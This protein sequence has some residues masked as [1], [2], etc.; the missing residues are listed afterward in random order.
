MN[1]HTN[2][3]IQWLDTARTC[4]II[5]VVLCH[6]TTNVYPIFRDNILNY[7]NFSQLFGFLTFTLGRIGVPVFLFISG[8]LLLSRT[9]DANS[10][11]K[12]WK[13]NLFPLFLASEIWIIVYYTFICQFKSLPFSFI[14]LIKNML[15]LGYEHISYLW[16][17][18]TILGLYL[19]LPFVAI[20]LHKINIKPIVFILFITFFYCFFIPSFNKLL[21]AFECSLLSPQLFLYFSGGIYGFYMIIGYLFYIKFFKK[22]HL[23][24]LFGGFFISVLLTALFQLKMYHMG[25]PY[26][27]WYDFFLLPIAAVFL[28]SFF[29]NYLVP[30]CISSFTFHVAKYSFG[31]Y[32]IHMPILDI[33]TKYISFGSM[34]TPIKLLIYFLLTFFISFF[35]VSSLSKIPVIR[36]YLFLIK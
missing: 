4:A 9:Y 24:Y 28:F 36:K 31:I 21:S 26:A 6:V 12:F 33:I 20:V 8:Y 22:L 17:L 7:S 25:Y 35:L 1:N 10:S 18:S 11:L 16:Y 27:I 29:Q 13:Y 14:T 5:L 34:F 15:F 32:L 2:R 23:I 30:S 19:C 3:R